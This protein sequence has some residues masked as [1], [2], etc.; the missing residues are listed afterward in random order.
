[1]PC[2]NTNELRVNAE[3]VEIVD[4][5]YILTDEEP[6]SHLNE[7]DDN[8]KQQQQQENIVNLPLNKSFEIKPFILDTFQT[9][10]N[11]S[12]TLLVIAQKDSIEYNNETE[13]IIISETTTTTTTDNNNNN[14]WKQ[15][16]E[17]ISLRRDSLVS[18]TPTKLS[19]NDVHTRVYHQFE[20]T[21]TEQSEYS[22]PLEVKNDDNNNNNNNNEPEKVLVPE[23][24]TVMPSTSKEEEEAVVAEEE[25]EETVVV[26]AAATTSEKKESKKGSSPSQ[27]VESVLNYAVS[28][29]ENKLS[30]NEIKTGIFGDD[31]NQTKSKTQSPFLAE[32]TNDF[33][34]NLFYL[35]LKV[36]F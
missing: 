10:T 11:S 22:S 15:N 14:V 7:T 9:A 36:L 1:L 6:D 34:S 12:E 25:E 17:L 24:E 3:P 27:S 21:E 18:E 8:N 23:T 35:I 4:D 20:Q 13:V 2:F 16:L 30:A 29:I 31:K 5:S 33:K 19:L 32:K 28:L 26:A